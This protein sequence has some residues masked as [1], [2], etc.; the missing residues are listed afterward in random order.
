MKKSSHRRH[1]IKAFLNEVFR[2]SESKTIVIVQ[3]TIGIVFIVAIFGSYTFQSQ[4]S[5]YLSK[6]LSIDFF[7]FFV[8]LPWFLLLSVLSN[9]YDR[10]KKT[11]KHGIVLLSR[12]ILLI[13]RISD[14]L[15]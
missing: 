7:R 3:R 12:M 14:L 5:S 10:W 1:V 11:V 8:L 4:L 6:H 13:I 2:D 9:Y 15:P